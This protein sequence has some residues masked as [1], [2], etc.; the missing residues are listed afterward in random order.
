MFII[1]LRQLTYAG[2]KRLAGCAVEVKDKDGS[3][4]VHLGLARTAGASDSVVMIE[5]VQE[6]KKKRGRPKKNAS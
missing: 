4:L 1:P 6:K 5:P 3:L 2:V